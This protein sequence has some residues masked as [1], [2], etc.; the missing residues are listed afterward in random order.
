MGVPEQD[1]LP[2]AELKL[3]GF[4]GLETGLTCPRYGEVTGP[5]QGEGN[6]PAWFVVFS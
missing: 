6:I 4:P 5:G 2:S 1:A 3:A